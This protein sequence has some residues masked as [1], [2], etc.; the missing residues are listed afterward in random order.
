MTFMKDMNF[1]NHPSRIV[2]YKRYDISSEMRN[3]PNRL[4]LLASSTSIQGNIERLLCRKWKDAYLLASTAIVC[5][6]FPQMRKDEN[7]HIY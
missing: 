4:R 1:F 5:V 7:S 3:S 2:L 6:L